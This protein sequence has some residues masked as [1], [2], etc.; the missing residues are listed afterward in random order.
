MAEKVLMKGN[1]AIA[2][3]AICAGCRH[4]FG[5]PITPQTEIA[6][7]MA[8]KM[9]KIGG[10]FLQAESEVAAINMVY[11]VAATGKRVMTSSSSPGI[12]LKAEGLSYLAGADLPAL[13]VNV[14][15]GGPGLGGIQPSQSDYF[16][17]TRGG[18]HGDYRMIV[19]APAS[20]QEMASLTVKGFDLADKYRMTAMIL[21]D[22]TM[23]QMM[24]PVSLDFPEPQQVEKPWATNGTDMK[25]EHNV[26][27]SL[28]LQPDA[29]EKTNFERYERYAYI[30]QNEALYE[31]YL[32]EDAE[33]CVTAFGIASRVAKNAINEARNMG[34]KVGMIRPITLWPFPVAPFKA[35]A[36]KV[37]SFISVELSMGQMI[38]DIRLATDCKKP[39]T[40]CN[41]A[42]GIIPSPEEVLAAIVK[43]NENGGDL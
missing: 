33:I 34:I 42:G 3:A 39:V 28:F 11:G 24:E 30:E 35:A 32:M 16:Q 4:Y 10:C 43:A 38:E 14:Q 9:P 13:V 29:L 27:N 2:E 7:Y 20:V 21:A 26:V 22:G 6:A 18:G 37:K 41:R 19:L 12:S 31:E 5:Y 8:K 15:R 36:D 25:R 23:G 40:L 17:A 1:E